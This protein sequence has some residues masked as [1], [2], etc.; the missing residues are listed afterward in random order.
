VKIGRVAVPGDAENA[1]RSR[2][3]AFTPIVFQLD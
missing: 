3:T 2:A 1:D